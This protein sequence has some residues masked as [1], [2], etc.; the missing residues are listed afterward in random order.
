MTTPFHALLRFTG[1]LSLPALLAAAPAEPAGFLGNF[2]YSASG[3]GA[4]VEN[5]SR[6]SNPLDMRETPVYELDFSAAASRQLARDWVLNYGAEAGLFTM[7]DFS[8]NNL[9]TYG[10][11]GRLQRK[12]G[13]GPLAPVLSAHAAYAMT[14]AR[15]NGQ[16]GGTLSGGVSFS[17]RLHPALRIGADATWLSHYARH[18]TYDLNQRT[19]SIEAVWDITDRL[20]LTGTAG[21][22]KGDIVATAGAVVWGRA[23]GGLLG[24]TIAEYY[25]R[26]PWE[27]TNAYAPGWVSYS[28][29]ADVDLW[30]VSLGYAF[31]DKT[32]FDLRLSSAYAVNIVNVRYLQRQWGAGLV[33]RF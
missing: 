18:N 21:W 4:W 25:N 12:F 26:T 33:H 9:F 19:F 7:P 23:I 22:L 17:K 5:Q 2:S 24:P 8:R 30:S 14:D 29:E 3:S 11:N 1:L 16:D 32:T 13:L 15:I 6:S 28:V 10:V 31:S 20:R 27:V